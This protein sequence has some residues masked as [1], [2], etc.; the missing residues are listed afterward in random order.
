MG[1]NRRQQNIKIEKSRKRTEQWRKQ[2]RT[3]RIKYHQTHQQKENDYSKQHY[4]N[5]KEYHR[6]ANKEHYKENKEK[7]Q[8]RRA[9][10][11][12]EWKFNKCSPTFV[13]ST[14]MSLGASLRTEKEITFPQLCA[15]LK[16]LGY[17]P[18]EVT[19]P[20]FMN[21]YNYFNKKR[22]P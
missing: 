17:D 2:T 18:K 9:I 19:Y 5:N 21:R 4:E 8:A 12:M 14:F 15:L 13:E 10:I 6:K 16:V 20:A 11:N 7:W 22:T 1:F 3:K